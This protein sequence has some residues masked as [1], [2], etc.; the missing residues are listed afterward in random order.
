MKTITKKETVTKKQAIAEAK[1]IYRYSDAA[2]M[3]WT[4]KEFIEDY[5]NALKEDGYIK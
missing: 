3:G 2:E 5:I 1:E 4:L